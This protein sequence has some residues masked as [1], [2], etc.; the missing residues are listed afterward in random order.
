[1]EMKGKVEEEVRL[2]KKHVPLLRRR[3]MSKQLR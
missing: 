3:P 2:W 1:M